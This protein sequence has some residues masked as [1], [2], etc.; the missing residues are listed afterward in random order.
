MTFHEKMKCESL[1]MHEGMGCLRN[2]LVLC[3]DVI[4]S[5]AIELGG[6]FQICML[7][8]RNGKLYVHTACAMGRRGSLR[9]FLSTLLYWDGSEYYPNSIFWG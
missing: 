3:G 1:A 4:H 5:S 9:Y 8:R 7:I 2:K 6:P